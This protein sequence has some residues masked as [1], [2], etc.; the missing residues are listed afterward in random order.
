MTVKSLW[1]DD[2][3]LQREPRLFS[4][5]SSSAVSSSAFSKAVVKPIRSIITTCNNRFSEQTSAH[6]LVPSS[7]REIRTPDKAV[8][9]GFQKPLGLRYFKKGAFGLLSM[10]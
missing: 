2:V 8:N 1:R 10:K 9:S 7:P 5:A 3:P 4:A 6:R